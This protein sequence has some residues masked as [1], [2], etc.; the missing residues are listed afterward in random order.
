MKMPHTQKWRTTLGS[1]Q[2]TKVPP[3]TLSLSI[4]TNFLRWHTF[5]SERCWR[6]IGIEL[7]LFFVRRTM[8]S[9]ERWIYHKIL[10]TWCS[11]AIPSSFR[12]CECVSIAQF[13]L[14][15]LLTFLTKSK[16][17]LVLFV[18]N[19]WNEMPREEYLIR[20]QFEFTV[21]TKNGKKIIFFSVGE[22][23]FCVCQLHLT[24][25]TEMRKKEKDW[26]DCV[27]HDGLRWKN[28]KLEETRSRP[29]RHFSIRSQ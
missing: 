18:F 20:C 3:H 15:F 21:K 6:K 10:L 17:V 12:T 9:H 27:W 24:G 28:M 1:L 11:N 19:L 16:W 13:S 2:N 5:G 25:G 22:R 26:I 14:F 7:K 29:Y 23:L 4:A 8:G